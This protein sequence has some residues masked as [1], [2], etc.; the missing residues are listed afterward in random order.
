MSL[1]PVSKAKNL[2]LMLYVS[3]QETLSKDL[4][5]WKFDTHQWARTGVQ[6]GFKWLNKQLTVES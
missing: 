4:D 1:K 3:I 2:K 6:S 5:T